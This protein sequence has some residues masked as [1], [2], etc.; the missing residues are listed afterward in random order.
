MIEKKSEEI[1]KEHI[2]SHPFITIFVE[3]KSTISFRALWK[4]LFT[5]QLLSK[6][7]GDYSI[8]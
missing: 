8:A 5:S 3:P 1:F 2:S 7:T 4:N 6:P